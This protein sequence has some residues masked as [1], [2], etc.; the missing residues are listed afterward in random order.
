MEVGI[1]LCV[2]RNGM[3][4]NGLKLCQERSRLD[5]RKKLLSKRV[6]RYWNGLPREVIDSLSL[7][8]FRKHLDVVLREMV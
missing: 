3:R 6:V 8:V 5:I 2:T 1:L 7:K 4:D